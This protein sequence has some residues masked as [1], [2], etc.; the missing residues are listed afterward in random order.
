MSST[1]FIE[2]LLNWEEGCVKEFSDCGDKILMQVEFSP[3]PCSCPQCHTTTEKAKVK[4]YRLQKIHVGCFNDRQIYAVVRKRRV[5]CP[6][7]GRTFCEP[8]PDVGKYQRRTGSVRQ[9]VLMD[10]GKMMS[11]S[12]V[13]RKHGI[14]QSTVTRIFE[15]IS[16]RRPGTL[17]QVLSID[18]FKGNTNQEKYQVALNDL[19]ARE[20]LD[21]LPSRN[22][23]QLI[24]YFM[25]FSRR[26]R[27]KVKIVVMDLSSLFRKVVRIVFPHATVVGDRFHIQRLVLWAMENVRKNVQK[28]LPD[29]IHVKRNKSILQKSGITLKDDELNTLRKI[30]NRSAKLRKAYALKECFRSIVRHFRTAESFGAHL[31]TWLQLVKESRLDEFKNLL[32]SFGDWRAEIIGGMTSEYSNGYTEG[33]NNRIKVIKRIAFGFQN[34]ERFRK[35]ILFSCYYAKYQRECSMEAA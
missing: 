5:L 24:Q 23:E 33:L 35:K 6:H 31:D 8:I 10:C 14:S 34:F 11:F 19:V 16:Y 26:E 27:L 9:T 25:R 28:E 17:P 3:K 21:I 7:C 30:L 2:S 12:D 18:E 22:T 15:R 32:R 29:G 20:P 4:D 13:A 1:Y